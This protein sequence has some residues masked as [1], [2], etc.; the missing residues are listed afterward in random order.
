MSRT[1]F[2]VYIRAAGNNVKYYDLYPTVGARHNS[3]M[4]CLHLSEKSF[5]RL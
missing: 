3:E 5:L 4:I 1:A 2:G